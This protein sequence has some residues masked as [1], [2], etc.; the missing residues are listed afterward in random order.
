[1]PEG[2]ARLLNLKANLGERDSGQ[3][4][5]GTR[6][7]YRYFNALFSSQASLIPAWAILVRTIGR[8]FST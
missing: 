5:P 8:A 3:G 2:R 7:V 6:R 4:E 1:M